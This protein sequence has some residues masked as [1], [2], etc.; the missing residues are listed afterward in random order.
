MFSRSS[1]MCSDQTDYYCSLS[2]RARR[3]F[4][5]MSG[6]ERLYRSISSSFS[7]LKWKPICKL[8]ALKLKRVLKGRLTKIL[9]FRQIAPIF[10]HE[11]QPDLQCREKFA[12]TLC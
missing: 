4:T 6:G 3:L 2:T 9:R 11:N 8:R 1:G 10:S 7:G 5:W 12:F